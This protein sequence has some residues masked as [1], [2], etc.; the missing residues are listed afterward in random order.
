MTLIL[1][2]TYVIVSVR[3][4]Y[5]HLYIHKS[6]FLKIIIAPRV[7]SVITLLNYSTVYIIII[8]LKTLSLSIISIPIYILEALCTC[9]GD[10]N[11]TH[12][13]VFDFYHI[14]N[15]HLF[16]FYDKLFIYFITYLFIL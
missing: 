8:S 6:W 15:N 3:L 2:H 12:D 9:T 14:F 10:P 7:V 16:V 13:F 11:C 1:C 4:N 5:M